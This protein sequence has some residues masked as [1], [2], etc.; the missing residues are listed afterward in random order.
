MGITNKYT[1]DTFNDAFVSSFILLTKEN[2]NNFLYNAMHS[3]VNKVVTVLYFL[4]CIF[5][6]HY[7]LLNL[8]LAILL[9]GF[10]SVEEEDHDTPEKK[11]KR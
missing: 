1:F 10:S 5:V 2:W 3:E 7:M 8:F 9:D 4:S 6:G 11:N